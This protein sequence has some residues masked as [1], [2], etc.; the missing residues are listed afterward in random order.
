MNTKKIEQEKRN[1]ICIIL[2]IKMI[3]GELIREDDATMLHM[4]N[5]V[6]WLC[7]LLWTSFVL[8]SVSSNTYNFLKKI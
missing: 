1:F 2:Y 5:P 7:Y 3:F 6:M 4:Y 8:K